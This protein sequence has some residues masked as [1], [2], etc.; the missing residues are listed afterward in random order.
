M[1]DIVEIVAIFVVFIITVFLM[2][3]LYRLLLSSSTLKDRQLSEALET[4]KALRGELDAQ[5]ARVEQAAADSR[6]KLVRASM[7]DG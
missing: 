3:L 4:A 7:G 1:H 2:I 6:R 5:R